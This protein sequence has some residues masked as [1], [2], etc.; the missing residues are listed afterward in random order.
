MPM[1]VKEGDFPPE[2]LQS[3]HPRAS[4]KP[5][6]ETVKNRAGEVPGRRQQLL[7]KLGLKKKTK[8]EGGA[9]AVGSAK[10]RKSAGRE[11]GRRRAEAAG[12]LNFCSER[13]LVL[14]CDVVVIWQL[15]E[16]GPRRNRTICIFGI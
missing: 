9:A 6:G 10:K 1:K 16:L 4:D 12:K 3:G 11:L 7:E 8:D 5:E 15:P 2:D 14:M 13:L